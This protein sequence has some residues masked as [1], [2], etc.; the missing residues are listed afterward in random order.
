MLRTERPNGSGLRVTC[1]VARRLEV[2][3][4]LGDG[5][6]PGRSSFADLLGGGGSDASHL[7]LLGY[8]RSDEGLR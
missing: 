2:L 7:L 4:A 6:I 1:F 5:F 8:R 3:T